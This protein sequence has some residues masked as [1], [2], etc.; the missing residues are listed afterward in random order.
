MKLK[1]IRISSFQLVLI[2]KFFLHLAETTDP[3][4]K[5]IIC[6]DDVP[7]IWPH[8]KGH[9]ISR[10]EGKLLRSYYK[11]KQD[12]SRL[13]LIWTGYRE[14]VDVPLN[15]FDSPE[16]KRPEAKRP[17]AKRPEAKR[18]KAKRPEAKR[19]K[20]KRPEKKP[21]K[22][23]DKE[24]N[25]RRALTT[26]RE[27]QPPNIVKEAVNIF[28]NLQKNV[29]PKDVAKRLQDAG[30]NLKQRHVILIYNKVKSAFNNHLK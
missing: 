16:T 22:L 29:S 5:C 20:A 13:R 6:G 17:K 2:K 9:R 19:P 15:Q 3:P 7:D 1:F 11:L 27:P 30:Y 4:E 23:E 14:K 21:Q 25:F 10:N 12:G 28:L 8:V 24:R 18:P 26:F